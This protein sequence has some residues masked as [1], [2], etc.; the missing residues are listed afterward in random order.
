MVFVLN[1]KSN[2]FF[3]EKRIIVI[4]KHLVFITA[5]AKFMQNGREPYE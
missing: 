2:D 5:Q 3:A 1:A 4:D